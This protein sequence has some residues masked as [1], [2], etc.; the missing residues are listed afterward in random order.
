MRQQ[1]D[2]RSLPVQVDELSWI[3]NDYGDEMLD[4][5]LFHGVHVIDIRHTKES[6]QG[7]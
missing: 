7:Q 3:K 4:V 2:V 6:S 5:S 1:P